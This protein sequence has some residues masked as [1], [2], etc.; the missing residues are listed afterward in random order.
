MP[1]AETFPF[2]PEAEVQKLRCMPVQNRLGCICEEPN[3]M[4]QVFDLTFTEYA[5][6]AGFEG[7]YET[8]CIEQ[9]GC[10]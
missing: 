2:E 1:Y 7:L 10:P 9:Y 6:L 3:V 8:H 4:M 5:L